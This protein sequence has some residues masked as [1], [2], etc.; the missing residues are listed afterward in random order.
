MEFAL[1]LCI[2]LKN[3]KKGMVC[4]F[5]KIKIKKPLKID[6]NNHVQTG[7]ATDYK[8]ISISSHFIRCF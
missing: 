8:G 2:N 6:K 5:D 3:G 7:F 1:I 4:Q